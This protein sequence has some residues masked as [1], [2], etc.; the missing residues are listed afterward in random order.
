LQLVLRDSGRSFNNIHRID[1]KGAGVSFIRSV[2]SK[3][4]E[5]Q[6]DLCIATYTTPI[7]YFIEAV[8][9]SRI[10]LGHRI[11]SQKWYRPRANFLLNLSRPVLQTVDEREPYRHYRLA[12]ALG[13][14]L[15]NRQ[16]EPRILVG[17]A[18][19]ESAAQFI[20]SRGLSTKRLIGVH[21][22]VSAAMSWKKWPDERWAEVLSTVDDENTF[23]LFF[24]S[25][26]ESDQIVAASARVR[27]H[28][29]EVLDQPI[30]LVAALLLRCELLLSNDSGLGHL[31]VAL[32]T[33]TLRIFG[34]S[35][36]YGCEPFSGPHVT[37]YR[38]LTCSPCMNLG[39]IKSGYNVLTCGHRNC[40]NLITVNDVLQSATTLLK[41]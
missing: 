32:G 30:E 19:Q 23:F 17:E 24:G 27:S 31:A 12:Q 26:Y 18:A 7:P 22:G 1:Y 2:N 34:P 29:T 8:R 36:H 15:Q 20:A 11:R 33:P 39:I 9:S 25:S 14:Q 21:I 41:R 40:L 10:R 13:I 35:D 38:D 4:K 3:L 37:L 28:A 16:P 5:T 6:Y